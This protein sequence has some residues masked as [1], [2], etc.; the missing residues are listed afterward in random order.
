M[1][2]ISESHLKKLTLFVKRWWEDGYDK[3]GTYIF[4]IDCNGHL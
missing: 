1:D 2:E 3:V 4:H